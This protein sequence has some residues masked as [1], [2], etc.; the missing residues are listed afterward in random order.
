MVLGT[1]SSIVGPVYQ[2]TFP[3]LA[4]LPKILS[5]YHNYQ[6]IVQLILELFNEYTKIVFLSDVS[7]FYLYMFVIVINFEILIVIVILT[8]YFIALFQA[9]SM[10]V[11]ETCMQ[12]M[13]TYARCN[14]HRFTVD[15]TAEEDSFQ[16][17]VLLMRLLTNLL[18]KDIFSLNHEANPS[19]SQ[20]A[21]AVPAVEP[22]PLTDVFLY[23]LNI[24]MPMM[25]IN[26]L[27]F[28]SLCLQ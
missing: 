4:E 17:I 25:T 10:R 28:P 18:I 20:L 9:D 22:V 3:I 19:I 13:Q 27:K 24:I 11:Y 14:S 8:Y 2:Y 15:S 21:S 12:M 1:E 7:N 5:L 6:D 16:D 26:L 23:G